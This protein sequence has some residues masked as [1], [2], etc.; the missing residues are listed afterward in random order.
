MLQPS[1]AASWAMRYRADGKPKKL[2]LGPWPAIDLAT[3]RRRAEE[4]RGEV[5]GG[6]DPAA[7]KQAARDARK[8]EQEASERRFAK[9]V[10]SYVDRYVKREL[11]AAWGKE[12]ERLLRVEILPALGDR[13]IDAV[14]RSHVLDLL[15]S[16]VDRGA[17]ITAN[18]V[19]AV[20]RQ[21][22]NW[23]LDRDLVKV[24]PMPRR[25]PALEQQRDRVLDDD[26]IRL[27]WKALDQIGGNFGAVG[28]LLLLTGAR[29]DEIAEG[30]WSEIDLET[31]TWTIPGARTKNGQPHEIPLSDAAVDILRRLPR[32]T[33]KQGYVF[34]TSGH[35][36]LRGF[37]GFKPKAD[38]MSGVTGWTFH[39]LRRTVATNLQKLGVRL[40]VTEA[41]LNHA[42]GSRAGVVGIYQRHTWA[43]EKRVA[44]D[45]WARRLE[46]IISG[47]G[48]S[49]VVELAG[50]GR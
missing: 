41:V 44:L 42:S 8:A 12:V 2:T 21:L 27:V 22:F 14:T 46:A 37:S 10:A 34:T 26:E 1:G 17:P 38:A 18:R 39:D 6:K 43:A 49:N 20:L 24:S 7:M 23:S 3:A 47:A 36:P 50:R 25:A 9:I 31:R 35:V 15:D 16:I 28:R 32:V 29:R 30:V 40:E 4:A 33:S 19:F 48:P 11:G 13:R 45:A 5:A